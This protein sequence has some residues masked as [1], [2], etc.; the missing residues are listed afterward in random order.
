LPLPFTATWV[1]DLYVALPYK[2]HQILGELDIVV[3]VPKGTRGKDLSVVL[4]KKQLSVGLKG[5]EPIMSGE[6]CK[7]IKVDDST[8]TLR[9]FKN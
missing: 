1:D 7:E 2:W 9:K 5:Q 8:W 6:L 3:P 4:K